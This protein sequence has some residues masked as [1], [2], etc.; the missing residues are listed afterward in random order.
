MGCP[1]GPTLARCFVDCIEQKLFENKSDFLPLVYLR[2]I[3]N[4]YCVFDTESAS[5]VF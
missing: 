5:L 4:I 3:D 1:L 2:Y